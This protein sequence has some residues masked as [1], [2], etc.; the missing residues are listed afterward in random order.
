VGGKGNG[1]QKRMGFCAALLVWLSVSGCASSQG[2]LATRIPPG[3]GAREHLTRAQELLASRSYEGALQEYQ[4]VLSLS[5]GNPPG[6]EA[7]LYVGQIYSDPRNPGKDFSKSIASFQKLIK[8]YPQSTWAESARVWMENLREQE[9]LGRVMVELLQDNERLERLWNG[10]LKENE[11]LKRRSDGSAQENQRLKK[12]VAETSQE[13]LRLKKTV[14]ETSQENLRLKKMVEES[15]AV[16]V[17]IDEKKR[18]QTK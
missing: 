1:T 15:K 2:Q 12:T 8:E 9:R 16:D 11:Q 6:D 17:E 4:T 14:E 7:L 13:N 3:D 5:E 18:E 10:V